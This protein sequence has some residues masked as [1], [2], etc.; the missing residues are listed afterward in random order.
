MNRRAWGT[1]LS[2]MAL[3][4]GIAGLMS[5]PW[6]VHVWN[7]RQVGYGVNLGRP[8]ASFFALERLGVEVL[9]YPSNAILLSLALVAIGVGWQRREQSIA[10]LSLWA[11]AMLVLSIPR[12]A[13]VFM[14]T[15]SVVIA[16]YIPVSIVIAWLT[17]W[18]MDHKAV[19]PPLRCFVWAALAAISLWGVMAITSIVAPWAAY[20]GPD[21]LAALRWIKIN[22]S[23]S[24][25]FMVNT[26]HWDFL[27]DLVIGSDAGYWLP[28]LTGRATVTIPMVYS[29]ERINDPTLVERL[30]ALDRLNGRLTSPEALSLLRREGVTHVYVG[31]QGGNIRVDDLLLSPDFVLEYQSGSAFVFRIVGAP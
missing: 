19:Q 31:Q 28:L 7:A 17:H 20:V 25:R 2:R 8:S 27:P 11:V 30:V 18:G 24:A 29:N 15:I 3:A 4:L 12:F 22:T 21:D 26:W 16:L 23:P 6:I 10:A 13:S 14:D 1:L 5:F 9:H